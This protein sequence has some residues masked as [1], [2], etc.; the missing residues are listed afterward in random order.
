MGTFS[1]A[2]LDKILDERARQWER[3]RVSLLEKTCQWL[4]RY[5]AT[6]GIDR[7]YLFGSITRPYRF[8]PNSDI[9]I[10]VETIDSE[11]HFLAISFLAEYLGREVDII[12]LKH[13]HFARRI[14]EEG[15]LW[16]REN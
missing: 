4:E 9:D 2:E 15:I 3:D 1:T 13:C 6:Y 16:T 14:Q 5:A 7:A 11:S 12:L 10:A 8:H